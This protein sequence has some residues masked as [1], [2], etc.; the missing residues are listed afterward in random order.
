M[1]P[2]CLADIPVPTQPESLP[3]QRDL[4]FEPIIIEE[5]Y[6]V[7]RRACNRCDA[8]Y[9]ATEP[10]CPV[11]F[12]PDFSNFQPEE[13]LSMARPKSSTMT[14]TVTKTKL[15]KDRITKKYK[16]E[17]DPT[18]IVESGAK[19]VARTAKNRTVKKV[20]RTAKKEKAAATIPEGR[21]V[22]IA[23]S[24]IDPDP[25]NARS[26]KEIRAEPETPQM[27]ASVQRHGVGQ[28][29]TVRESDGR[30]MVVM[31]H[32]RR[33]WA[34]LAGVESLQCIVREVTRDEAAA[35]QII[36]NMLRKDL[37]P[38]QEARKFQ[39]LITDL[40]WPM[41]K[42]AEVT[43][44]S[45][46]H[47]SGRL[48]LLRL[49]KPMQEMIRAKKLTTTQARTIGP[50]ADLPSVISQLSGELMKYIEAPSALRLD[51]WEG[52]ILSAVEDWMRPMAQD[53]SDAPNFL[54]TPEQYKQL[55]IRSVT[56]SH[57]TGLWA[58]NTQ[59]WDEL[60]AAAKA[61]DTNDQAKATDTNDQ[62]DDTDAAEDSAETTLI[63]PEEIKARANHA[64]AIYG[65]KLYR[66][67]VSWYQNAL[68]P[69]LK[70]LTD[71]QILV[72]VL[73]LSLLHPDSERVTRFNR[74]MKTAAG[75][76]PFASYIAFE[77]QRWKDVLTFDRAKLRPVLVEFFSLW[78]DADAR[79]FAGDA[80]PVAFEMLAGEL[81][82]DFAKQWDID[83]E[84]LQLHTVEQLID[85]MD[86]L[87]M[88][89][90]P[91]ALS[92][93]SEYVDHLL[94]T[95]ATRKTPIPKCLTKLKPVALD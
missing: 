77:G 82:I 84:F 75:T 55:D 71:E 63:S 51:D 8:V 17:F 92:K 9:P 67:Q 5:I 39:S 30:Y 23:L 36:E 3:G 12:N 40:K 62:A 95:R 16:D 57:G 10:C 46:P 4:F 13:V 89:R 73:A 91:V 32:R 26:D 78:C 68:R 15:P 61:T 7:S 2:T 69:R 59:L 31:G 20:A 54:W 50:L 34:M 58:A 93:K 22:T 81:R 38:L 72:L 44:L 65:K 19:K 52:E 1:S 66:Y 83:K 60:Q 88:M 33:V 76:K 11:C 6:D 24:L 27:V 49:P 21:L 47:I 85:L 70:E 86:E 18:K 28:P 14:M 42:L 79:S 80:H 74:A 45:Q 37:D 48:K 53:R 25:S 35:L 56:L 43:G 29:I 64:L 90:P 87:E 41:E 94:E